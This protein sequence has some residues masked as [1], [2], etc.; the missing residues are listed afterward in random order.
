MTSSRTIFILSG[1]VA[2]C[3]IVMPFAVAQLTPLGAPTS[4]VQGPTVRDT[5]RNAVQA[6]S[7]QSRLTA[8]TAVEMGRRARSAGYQTQNFA[9]DYQNLQ[10]QFQN[11]RAVF[12]QV[13]GLVPQIQSPSASNSAAELDAGLNIIAEVFGPVEQDYQAGTLSRDA[14]VRMCEV[15]DEALQEWQKELKKDS[16]RLGVI[17]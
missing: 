1:I 5:L 3:V 8:Q 4:F 2:I 13:V 10:F 14:I 9:A 17:R 12:S 16:R 6:A 15:L 7:D 11:L